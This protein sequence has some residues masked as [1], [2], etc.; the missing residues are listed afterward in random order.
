[1]TIQL[2]CLTTVFLKVSPDAQWLIA[3]VVLVTK[4]INDNIIDKLITKYA[5][6]ENAVDA[7]FVG[8]IANNVM[9]SFWLAI[10]LATTATKASGYVILAIN[11]GIN[12]T[13]CHKVIRMNK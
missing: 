12:M 9:Y 3:L 4:E 10:T 11:F 8:S 7:K 2:R 1:M 5:S 13:L 6:P